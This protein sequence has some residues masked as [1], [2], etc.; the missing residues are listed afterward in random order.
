[1]WVRSTLENPTFSSQTKSE[2]TL[3]SQKFG[4]HFEIT[5]KFIK[6]IVNSGVGEEALAISKF[7]ESRDLKKDGWFQEESNHWYTKT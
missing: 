1:M 4:S 3:K 6:D 5:P 7:Q 2:C